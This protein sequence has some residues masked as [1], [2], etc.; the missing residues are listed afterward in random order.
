MISFNLIPID[1]RV[2]GQYIEID[3]SRAVRGLPGMPSRLL[4][5][6]QKLAAG[7]APALVPVDVLSADQAAKLF[8]RGSMLH[9]MVTAAKANNRWTK[10]T[11]IPVEDDPAG[12]AAAGA[13]TFGGPATAAGT[14][15]L[16]IGGQRVRVGVAATNTAAQIA[17]AAAAAINAVPDLA[18]TAAVDG[19]DTAKVNLTCKWKGE[20][21]NAIDLRHSYYMGEGLPAGVTLAIA[22]MAGG[23]ANPDLTAAIAA[24]ADAW[25]TDLAAPYTDAAN[26]GLV[27]AEAAR[28]YG[29]TVMQDLHAYAF[30]G[31]SH[32][33]LTTLG[34]SR[35]SP[36]LS[37]M[38]AKGVPTPPW[39]VAA[40]L[41]AVCAY[42]A[43][44]DAARPFQ[45]LPL[46]GVLAPAEA[47]RFDLEERNLLLFDGIATFKV[48]DGGSVLIERVVTTYQTNTYS[49]DDISYLDAETL[50]TVAY[51]RYSVRARFAMRFPRHKLAD[52]GTKFGAGQAI[53]TPS[54]GRAELLALAA[55]WQAAGLVENID[56]FKEDLLVER[57]G[58]DPNRMNALIPPD[59]VNQFRVFAGQ[60]QFRL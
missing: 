25:Y 37:I 27:E 53:V 18:A 43:R 49:I 60:V 21:G 44:I 32:G 5:L 9:R 48:D 46:A 4:I 2:P 34:S 15:A 8:G 26:L 20:S 12:A 47:D 16:M 56:Q 59:L 50:K 38:G 39:E 33:A 17:T 42:H 1:L 22:P 58:S 19:V 13:L 51:I 55:D 40:A 57:D 54:V 24:M 28:R 29:P 6:G 52:D 3:N 7:T 14:V 45:S 35:N 23:T 11:V 41:A 36:H 30:A 10:T 31:G